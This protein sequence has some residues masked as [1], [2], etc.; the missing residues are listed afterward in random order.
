[1]LRKHFICVFSKDDILRI[2]VISKHKLSF[3][4]KKIQ[5]LNFN[6]GL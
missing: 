3:N 1:M 4:Q 5:V 6:D 2:A